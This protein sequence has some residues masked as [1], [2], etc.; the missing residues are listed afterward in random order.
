M[1]KKFAIVAIISL[2]LGGIIGGIAGSLYTTRT[3]ARVLLLLKQGEIYKTQDEA[4]QAYSS[5]T[6]QIAEWELNQAVAVIT[7]ARGYGYPDT[8]ELNLLEFE[9]EA[10]LALV[11]RDI[12]NQEEFTQHML[13]AQ[14]LAKQ[15]PRFTSLQ[16]EEQVV[17]FIAK[18]D[19]AQKA[20]EGIEQAGPG[21]PPQ[22][23]G[24]PDP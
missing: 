14:I 9:A 3:F 17:D 15:I 20:S 16:T 24:S 2:L 23:V 22:G 10:R 5:G 11:N 8:N 21:Y 13:R 6:P 19:E 12:Q 18:W 4:W 1:K 7:D